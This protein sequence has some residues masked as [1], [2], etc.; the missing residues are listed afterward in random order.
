MV[1]F[2]WDEVSFPSKVTKQENYATSTE[3]S[4]ELR[5]VIA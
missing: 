3:V 2:R 4:F 1:N 5:S